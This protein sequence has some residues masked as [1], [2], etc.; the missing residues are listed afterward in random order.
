MPSVVIQ[1]AAD[2]TVPDWVSDRTSF[3]RWT[4]ED[5]FPN[6]GRIDYLAGEIWIDMSEEQIYS[7][8]QVKTE[9]TF[10]LTGLAKASRLGRFYQDGL[11][12]EHPETDLAAVPDGV[13][14]SRNRLETLR[15]RKVEGTEGGY[16]RMEGAPDMVLEVVS[17]KSVHKD[18]IRLRD[19][20][21][22]AGVREYWL[23]DARIEPLSFTIWKHSAKGFTTV[24]SRERWL[25]SDVFGKAF[26]LTAGTDELGDPEYTLETR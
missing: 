18:A 16:V 4:E 9:F 19:L 5:S 21:W 23:V 20:Y 24:R 2:V 3:L 13:Y 22:Q 25:K 14:I 8:N 10:V 26:R 15:I 7:H 1:Q 17:E 6:Q 12:I 11:R